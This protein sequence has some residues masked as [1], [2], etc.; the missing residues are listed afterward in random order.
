VIEA[1]DW[2][3]MSSVSTSTPVAQRILLRVR[4]AGAANQVSAAERDV[5]LRVAI[6]Q[7]DAV[8][9]IEGVQVDGGDLPRRSSGTSAER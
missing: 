7:R 4:P 6:A 2:K 8:L 3:S 9:Q 5:D 1:S